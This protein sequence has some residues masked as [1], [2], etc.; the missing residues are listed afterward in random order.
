VRPLSAGT[1][2]DVRRPETWWYRLFDAAPE[3]VGAAR[4]FLAECLGGAPETDHA[5][6]CLSELASNAILHS[7][8]ARPGGQFGVRVRRA[9]GWLRVEVT[10]EG[11][12]W[13][14]AQPG[15]THGRGLLVV[16]MIAGYV[17]IGDPGVDS[18]AR[19]VAFEMGCR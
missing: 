14:P 15:D 12:R 3:Q 7:R 8:S 5:L 1:H 13:K 4:R 9:P 16:Q 17:V 18:P 11:G 6:R 19:T 10:D 2:P